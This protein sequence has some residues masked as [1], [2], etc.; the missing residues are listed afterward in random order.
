MFIRD[1]WYM[2]GWA[3]DF[4][5]AKLVPF[6]L[7]SEK[8]VIFRKSDGSLAALADRCSHRL[9]PLS[10]GRLECDQI[11][12]MYHGLK[13]DS[14]GCNTE[15]PFGGRA[16]PTM[17]V[18]SY[19]IAERHS[20]VWVWMGETE[21][22][23]VDQIPPFVGVD[24]PDW[25]LAPGRMDYKA[26]YRLVNDNLLD[27]SHVTFVHKDSFLSGRGYNPKTIDAA[28]PTVSALPNGVQVQRLAS[29]VPVVQFLAHRFEPGLMCDQVMR[30]DFLLPG[31]F[32]M[33]HTMYPEGA[34]ARAKALGLPD[35]TVSETPLYDQFTCQAVTPITETSTCYFW[36]FGPWERARE[37]KDLFAT[38]GIQAFEEDR[39][40]VEGQQEIIDGS[41]GE[42]MKL[43][44]MD[45]AAV[46]Y[47]RLEAQRMEAG[48][49]DAQLAA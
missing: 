41:P 17:N 6:T 26:N 21:K 37:D 35:G 36:A 27:L 14:K 18:R 15:V 44:A 47:G 4:P 31:V 13:F 24:H 8:L 43:L 23:D 34:L 33:R 45:G 11:R 32:L 49:T 12:C 28:R 22:A 30:Y 10:L 5:E 19:P 20:G 2:V 1:A 38:L 9:A 29:S 3:Q 42:R 40:M 16:S 48:R 7:L 25:A 46:I 39:M